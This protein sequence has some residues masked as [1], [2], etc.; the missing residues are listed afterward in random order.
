M[1]Q[2]SQG[3]H[4]TDSRD[5]H[6]AEAPRPRAPHRIARAVRHIIG[7]LA[8]LVA[9]AAVALAL[10]RTGAL[11]ALGID[12]T[13]L[14]S[15]GKST[16]TL[17]SQTVK[18]V[19]APASELVTTKY[20]YTNSETYRGSKEV[21]D[22]ELPGT[23]N[24]VVY[25]YSGTVSLGIDLSQASY[26]VD[27][28]AK[29]IV[30]TLPEV[31]I[32]SNEIDQSSFEPQYESYSALNPI[33]LQDAYKSEADL[34]QEAADKVMAND[35]LL[36]DAARTARSVIR[37]FLTSADATRDYTVTFEGDADGTT[38]AAAGA[39]SSSGADANGVEGAS[40]GKDAPD[41]AGASSGDA[42]DATAAP[43]AE[44]R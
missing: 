42:S 19:V 35:E 20:Y 16:V 15:P 22:V 8:L 4:G 33:T 3:Q 12:A 44:Q 14:L 37:D 13:S 39:A 38:D 10:T 7:V 11:Q 21:G 6:G 29:T 18:E 30:V 34:K 27:N 25:T 43:A 40:G 32:T 17:T 23:E 28:D 5:A 41:G 2:T 26:Q 1:S 9:G 24:V 31:G 36:T